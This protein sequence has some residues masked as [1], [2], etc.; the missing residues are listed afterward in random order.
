[1]SPRK[2]NFAPKKFLSA[3]LP[4][5]GAFRFPVLLLNFRF[6]NCKDRNYSLK[7][8]V[9]LYLVRANVQKCI[10]DTLDF[11]ITSFQLFS[12]YHIKMQTSISVLH[13]HCTKTVR[14]HPPPPCL[15][16]PHLLKTIR[17][18]SL[19]ICGTEESEI[20]FLVKKQVENVT[21]CM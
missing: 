15:H 5:A 20:V 2:H 14:Q 8:G 6:A 17:N 13:K 9:D 12:Q 19:D 3:K 11:S 21:T 16:F 7:G 10:L 18:I 1:M 4:T